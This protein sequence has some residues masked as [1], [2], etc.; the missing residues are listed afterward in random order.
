MTTDA[1]LADRLPLARR[2]L[3]GRAIGRSL[4]EVERV[5]ATPVEE[6]VQD[7]GA[8]PDYLAKLSGPTQLTF[9]GGLVHSLAVWPSQLSLLV[10][11]SP[12]PEDPYADRYRLS[13]LG[14][15]SW[16][17]ALVGL[18]VRDVRVHLYQDEVPSD[19]ARQA[20]VSYV[21]DEG[22]ELYYCVYLHGRMDGDELLLPGEVIPEAVARSVSL[23]ASTNSP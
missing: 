11:D 12:L 7:G 15:P 18:T 20:A 5:T 23:S 21:F 19:E 2:E 22:T 8:A 16:L 17:R 14:A 3:L 10:E 4:V 6:F 9:S 13:E 1:Q